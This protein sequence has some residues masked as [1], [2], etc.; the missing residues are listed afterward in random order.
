MSFIFQ[1]CNLHA[2]SKSRHWVL[3]VIKQEN[4][5]TNHI[6]W[7]IKLY[8]TFVKAS[9]SIVQSNHALNYMTFSHF[10]FVDIRNDLCPSNNSKRA[11]QLFAV[12]IL[13]YKVFLEMIHPFNIKEKVAYLWIMAS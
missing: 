5:V 11:R 13:M 2:S 1:S 8:E 3:I 9:F 12:R 10:Y 7:R 4:T 6:L